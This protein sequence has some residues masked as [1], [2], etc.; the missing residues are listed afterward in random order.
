MIVGIEKKEDAQFKGPE[1][2]FNKII[3]ENFPNLKKEMPVNIQ[4]T[5]RTPNSLDQK[6]IS[7]YHITIK[8]PNAQKKKEY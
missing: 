8:T 7:T 1:N 2:I 4:E 5:Y 6:R 3:E